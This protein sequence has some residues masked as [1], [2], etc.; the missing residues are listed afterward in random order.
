MLMLVVSLLPA[1]VFAECT[2]ETAEE[3]IERHLEIRIDALRPLGKLETYKKVTLAEREKLA[4]LRKN[5]KAQERDNPQDIDELCKTVDNLIAVADDLLA[6]GDGLS[7]PLK[8]PWKQHT[9][10]ALFAERDRLVDLCNKGLMIC[11]GDEIEA[12]DEELH[13][14]DAAMKNG[15]MSA[16]DA[17]DGAYSAYRDF[18]RLMQQENGK[19]NSAS[20]K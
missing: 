11:D 3:Q 8:K 1:C 4:L 2:V 20:E 18:F 12:M 6:G 19:A 16:A 5:L 14:L 9:P 15:K 13:A 7:P 10:E 17:I